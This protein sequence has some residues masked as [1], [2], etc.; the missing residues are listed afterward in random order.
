VARKY[1][2][3]PSKTGCTSGFIDFRVKRGSTGEGYLS[4]TVKSEE[5]W[6]AGP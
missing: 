6:E 2:I 5:M 4:I 1:L 3:G